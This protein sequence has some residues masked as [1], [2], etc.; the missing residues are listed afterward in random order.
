[1]EHVSQSV[2]ARYAVAPDRSAPRFD[3]VREH[4]AAGCVRCAAFVESFRETAK[5]STGGHEA[6]IVPKL[7]VVGR[8]ARGG[9]L[10]DFHIVCG[11]GPFELDVLVREHETMP[12][13]EIVGQVTRSG[14]IYDPV[15]NLPLGLVATA[16]TEPVVEA[17]TDSFGEFNLGWRRDGAYGLRLGSRPDAPCVL[18]WEGG[19]PQ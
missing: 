14:H 13:L 8:D 5:R 4:L 9:A 10:A 7:V 12:E 15:T 17:T 18:V 6:W 19:E 2:L 11:A 16:D 1:M 3:Q